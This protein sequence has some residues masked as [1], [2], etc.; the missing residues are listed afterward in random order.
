MDEG[1]RSGGVAEGI[2]TALIEAGVPSAGLARVCGP[3]TFIPLGPA[4]ELVLPS[5]QS[6]TKAA[7][8]LLGRNTP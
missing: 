5:A 3:D 1:R 6:V 8:E 2:L 7:L 4:A